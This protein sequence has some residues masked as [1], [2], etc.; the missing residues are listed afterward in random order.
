MHSVTFIVEFK[1]GDFVYLKVSSRSK[2]IVNG[3]TLRETM[4]VMYLVQWDDFD[5]KTH[6]ATELTTVKPDP[7]EDATTGGEDDE[8]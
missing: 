6:T 5:E 3:Y 7:Y 2:G 8:G 1:I 4:H